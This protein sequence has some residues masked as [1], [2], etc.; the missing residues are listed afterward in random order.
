MPLRGNTKKACPQ[1]KELPGWEGRPKDEICYKCQNRW[2]ELI[3]LE[4][5]ILPLMS[6]CE[7][8]YMPTV[9]HALP[10]IFGKCHF[11][12]RN[13]KDDYVSRTRTSVHTDRV[14]EGV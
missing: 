3:A 13:R 9:A 8:R 5:H 7:V 4:Q 11:E 12:K 1:C 6:E 14:S 2:R 10:P